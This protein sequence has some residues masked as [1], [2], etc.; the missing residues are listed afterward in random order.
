MNLIKQNKIKI[1]VAAL[2]T[3][4]PSILG[5]IFMEFLQS[6]VTEELIAGGARGFL[7]FTLVFPVVLLAIFLLM[8]IVTAYDN[9]HT[10]Q[11]PKMFSI[12]IFT[13]PAI[14][15]YTSGI[16][17]SILFG[18]EFNIYKISSILFGVLFAI[19]GNYMPKCKPNFT[20]GIKTRLTLANSENWKAT[21]RFAGRVWVICGLV[22]LVTAFIPGFWSIISVLIVTAFAVVIPLIY[23]HTY[24]KKQLANGTWVT[25]GEDFPRPIKKAGVISIIAVAIVLVFCV[26]ITF[27]GRITVELGE[28]QLILGA[29][30]NS[31]LSINYS[32]IDSLELCDKTTKNERLFGFQSASMLIGTFRNDKFSTHTRYT[33]TKCD[34]EIVI[35]IDEKTVV[36]NT[37]TVEKTV[38]IYNAVLEK[39]QKGE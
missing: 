21:H 13:M 22:C 9:K 18:F 38:E 32:D 8:L 39:I 4:L 37:E 35:R 2:I 14:S 7:I 12:L 16:F 33:H 36:F 24:Y 30:F 34:K 23:S 6:K 26:I 3:V 28:E 5:L 27:A 17:A 10:E 11:S 1:A 19:I 20:M 29:T 15:L 25:D 31:P